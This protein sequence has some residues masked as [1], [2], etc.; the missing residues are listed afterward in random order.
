[1]EQIFD[2]ELPKEFNCIIKKGQI[3]GMAGGSDSAPGTTNFEWFI[4]AVFVCV[5]IIVGV[6]YFLLK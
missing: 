6:W 1:L 5:L 4:L 2:E 3:M